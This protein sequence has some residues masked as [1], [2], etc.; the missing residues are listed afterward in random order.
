MVRLG[1]TRAAWLYV[2]TTASAYVWLPI[3]VILGLPL[4]IA[5]AT[6]VPLPL[7][8]WRIARISDHRDRHAFE[9][10]TL[11]AVALVAATAACELI[12]FLMLGA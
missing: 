12:G 2:A 8:L 1:V 9:R 10:L 4:A 11:F 3:A 5:V 6:A 7:A